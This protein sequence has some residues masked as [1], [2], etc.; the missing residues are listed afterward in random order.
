MLKIFIKV[1]FNKSIVERALWV[2]LVVGII[3][4]LINQWNNIISVNILEINWYKF[5]LTFMVPY[6]VSTFSSVL[7]RIS[8]RPGEVANISV[9]AIC[10]GGGFNKIEIV[11]GDWVP[12]CDQCET[13]TNWKIV[14]LL[15]DNMALQKQKEK[16]LSLFAQ[17]N[18][19]PVIRINDKFEIQAFNDTVKFIFG[20]NFLEGKNILDFLPGLDPEVITKCITRGIVQRHQEKVA[21]KDIL[22]EL[23]GIPE[24]KSCQLYAT[25]I[26]EL[27]KYSGR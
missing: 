26:T 1:A 6:L 14:K 20:E 3:L 17:F 16:S 27:K 12:Y 2:T 13:E 8:L 19:N 21:D 11:K 22:F 18:P 15:D 9:Q 7:L 23:R 25:D 10:S 4:N 24:M 5:L